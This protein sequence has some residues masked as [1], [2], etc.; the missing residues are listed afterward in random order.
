MQQNINIDINQTVTT[1]NIF[2]FWRLR[3]ETNKQYPWCT[4]RTNIVFEPKMYSPQYIPNEWKNIA[5]EE[6]KK[7]GAY[8]DEKHRANRQR[9]TYALWTCEISA[10]NR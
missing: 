5:I 4:H 8:N 2:N 3:Q 10:S 9:K 1:L 6:A 7:H